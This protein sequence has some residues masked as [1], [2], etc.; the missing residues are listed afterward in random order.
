MLILLSLIFLFDFGWFREQF[1]IV[2]CPYGRWQSVWLDEKSMVVGYD[3]Y[4]GEPRR[5]Q[6]GFGERAGDC[7]NC[8]RCIQVCPTGIDIRRGVQ[9]E[10]IA[11]TACIDTCDEVMLA[12]GKKPGLVRYTTQAL[13]TSATRS[14]RSFSVVWRARP[15]SYLGVVAALLAGFA[16]SQLY[17]EP[18]WVAVHRPPGPPYLSSTLSDGSREIVNPLRVSI[19]NQLSKPVRLTIEIGSTGATPLNGLTLTGETSEQ[20]FQPGEKKDL[21]VFAK[22][23]SAPGETAV[24]RIDAK[25]QLI[26]DLPASSPSTLPT[27]E[28][29]ELMT[30]DFRFLTP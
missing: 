3:A 12:L 27:K 7:V 20:F 23:K 17:R 28:S 29:S 26:L 25:L 4:R 13:L 5:G 19:R 9:M 11:C 15:I 18:L 1:C 24:L 8:L 10:C 22:L 14:S 6:V 30:R 2:A 16:Y 21:M